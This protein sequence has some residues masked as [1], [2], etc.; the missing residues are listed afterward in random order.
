MGRGLQGRRDKVF[1]MTKVC[2]HGRDKNVAMQQL[3]ESEEALRYAM[4][5]PVATTISGMDSLDVLRQNLMIVRG[6]E[7]MAPKEMQAL[8]RAAGPLPQTVT[9]SCTSR[10]KNTTAGLAASSM[11]IRQRISSR[12]EPKPSTQ[13]SFITGAYGRSLVSHAPDGPV[14]VFRDEQGTVV[15]NSYTDRTA[16][17]L[18]IGYDEA[19]HEIFV[20]PGRFSGVIEQDPHNFVPGS[21]A[22]VP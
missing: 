18:F 21:F 4:S 3:E 10:P 14:A 15:R 1:L 2:T 6:F 11:V 9:S 13:K 20:C 7:P 16:P 8:R 17:H 12:C 19:G 22:A 5:M